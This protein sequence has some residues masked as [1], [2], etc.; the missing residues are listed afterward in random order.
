MT[1]T[2]RR[3]VNTATK[4]HQRER[5][6]FELSS[7]LKQALDLVT[8]FNEHQLPEKTNFNQQEL[9]DIQRYE[10]DYEL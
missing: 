8:L 9:F 7:M 3:T 4:N 6:N 5:E 1:Q 2:P 10:L